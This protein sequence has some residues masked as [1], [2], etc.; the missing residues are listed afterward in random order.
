VE[1]TIG[2]VTDMDMSFKKIATGRFNPVS[3]DKELS[4]IPVITVLENVS[5]S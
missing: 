2:I 4:S 1:A 3:V 5:L